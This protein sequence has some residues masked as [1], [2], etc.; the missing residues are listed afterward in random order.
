L[1]GL[2]L[3]S[4]LRRH[5]L[6]PKKRLGQNFLVDERALQRV[7]AAAEIEPGDTVLEIGPGAGSLT[8][9][10]ARAAGRVL[11][12]EI[13]PQL[14]PILRQ[15]VAPFENV[16]IVQADIL[17]FLTEF[18]PGPG[19]PPYHVVANIPYYITAPILRRLMEARP[20]PAIVVLTVQLEVAERICAE[21][22]DLS[23]LAVSVQYHGRP[24]IVARIPAGAFYP[25]PEVDS[26]LV[27]I[28][29]HPGP[30]VAVADE[31]W[32]FHVVQA[33]FKQKRKQLKNAL[34]AGLGRPAARL[35]PALRAAGVEPSRRAETLSLEEWARVAAE[36]A[37]G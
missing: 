2:H 31:A 29:P 34:A 20:R 23:L 1:P 28:V 4:L 3:P 5:G 37:L 33:G 30:P 26:A 32:F 10:L 21:P 25:P 11:A 13:D 24:S 18:R 8:R 22:G 16:E 7:V 36:T 17:D 9:H 12:V 19:N 14:I 27:R 6:R 35:E 15:V